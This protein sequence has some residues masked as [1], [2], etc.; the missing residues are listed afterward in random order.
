[1]MTLSKKRQQP[2]QQPPLYLGGTELQECEELDILGVS[3]PQNLSYQSH[4]DKVAAKAGKR[5]NVLR[6]IGPY[7]DSKGRATVYKAHIRSTMEYAPLCWM[8]A[9]ET[10]L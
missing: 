2:Q 8:S 1:M 4:L 7:L 3:F 9:S 10:Q 5:V 6:K